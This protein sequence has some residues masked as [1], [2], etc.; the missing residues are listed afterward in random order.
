MGKIGWDWSHPVIL[1]IRLRINST[2]IKK[3]NNNPL[4]V[5]QDKINFFHTPTLENTFLYSQLLLNYLFP[6]HSVSQ[7]SDCF[8]FSHFLLYSF[9]SFC[10]FSKD[11]P[12]SR[13]CC[14]HSSFECTTAWFSP[15]V[16]IPGSIHW[17]IPWTMFSFSLPL[18]IFFYL[19]L[20][21]SPLLLYIYSS[22]WLCSSFSAE[23]IHITKF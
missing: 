9:S 17:R 1:Y 16:L 3:K 10:F 11:D 18:P 23:K 7:E 20:S 4:W 6:T 15:F 19:I 12:S 8:P 13:S 21:L 2:N 14:V 22:F 5:K